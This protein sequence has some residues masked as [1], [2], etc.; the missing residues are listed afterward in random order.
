LV[1][2]ILVGATILS[3]VGV[4]RTDTK[5]D[6]TESQESNSPPK[7][8][9]L[10]PSPTQFHLKMLT[11]DAEIDPLTDDWGAIGWSDPSGFSCLAISAP[12]RIEVRGPH[13]HVVAARRW[14]WSLTSWISK[15]FERL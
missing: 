12:S 2:F 8:Y 10:P 5:N 11:D 15:L 7:I 13:H 6:A 3:N 1:G 9:I 4:E 14:R